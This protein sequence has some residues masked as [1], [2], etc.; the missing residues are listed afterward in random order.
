MQDSHYDGYLKTLK[1]S[2][3]IFQNALLVSDPLLQNRYLH[4]NQYPI[5]RPSIGDANTSVRAQVTQRGTK[6]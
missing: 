5:D 6:K 4:H 1:S 3:A 2:D